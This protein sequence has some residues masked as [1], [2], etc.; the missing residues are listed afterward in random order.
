MHPG[1]EGMYPHLFQPESKFYEPPLYKQDYP[2]DKATLAFLRNGVKEHMISRGIHDVEALRLQLHNGKFEFHSALLYAILMEKCGGNSELAKH[3]SQQHLHDCHVVIL[4]V[5]QN[6][7]GDVLIFGKDVAGQAHFLGQDFS[8]C[9]NLT[10]EKKQVFR[11]TLSGTTTS[12]KEFLENSLS[13][14]LEERGI[15]MK[16]VEDPFL[17]EIYNYFLQN[18]SAYD[19]GFER[20]QLVWVTF[21]PEQE[22][23]MSLG[24]FLAYWLQLCV[25]EWSIAHTCGNGKSTLKKLCGGS[26]GNYLHLR[27]VHPYKNN[28]HDQHHKVILVKY[29]LQSYQTVIIFVNMQYANCGFSPIFPCS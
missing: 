5:R 18:P 28:E 12:W 20:T 26:C 22:F 13:N 19:R 10:S 6:L 27:M 9:F 4:P 29:S 7:S 16:N 2:V 8:S 23:C 21:G 24:N 15:P 14:F 3:A 25:G 11:G 1:Q 17:R